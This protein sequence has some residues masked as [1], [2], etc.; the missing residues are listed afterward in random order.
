MKTCADACWASSSVRQQSPTS[1]ENVFQL[2]SNST[3][4]STASNQTTLNRSTDAVTDAISRFITDPFGGGE[5]SSASSSNPAA[6]V[7]KSFADVISHTISSIQGPTSSSSVVQMPSW[8]P[9]EAVNTATV[10]TSSDQT[11]TSNGNSTANANATSDENEEELDPALGLL[12]VLTHASTLF[13][14][15][16]H[17]DIRAAASVST[18]SNNE[19][20]VKSE[21]SASSMPSP[22]PAARTTESHRGRGDLSHVGQV[23]AQQSRVSPSSS[24]SSNNNSSRPSNLVDPVIIGSPDIGMDGRDR[25][26]A[27]GDEGGSNDDGRDRRDGPSPPGPGRGPDPAPGPGA[28][29]GAGPAGPGMN[30]EDRANLERLP[31]ACKG[32]QLFEGAK[33][34]GWT[35]MS[36]FQQPSLAKAASCLYDCAR[37]P[38]ISQNIQ[39]LNSEHAKEILD[40]NAKILEEAQKRRRKE[41]QESTPDGL[42][43]GVIGIQPIIGGG[44]SD[45]YD[46]QPYPSTATYEGAGP[47]PAAGPF[48]TPTAGPTSSR[49]PSRTPTPTPLPIRISGDGP[50]PPIPGARDNNRNE[51]EYEYESGYEPTYDDD[52]RRADGDRAGY[53]DEKYGDGN[54][55]R[56][57]DRRSGGYS[58]QSYRYDNERYGYENERGNDYMDNQSYRSRDQESKRKGPNTNVASERSDPSFWDDYFQ[59]QRAL[60]QVQGRQGR[61][62]G[63]FAAQSPRPD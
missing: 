13:G 46:D 56:Y 2:G 52:R 59:S 15:T 61:S 36:I 23:F 40:R 57:G 28:G 4:N 63:S 58:D 6:S 11:T 7:V 31:L 60:G 29:A 16:F 54:G 62:R 5:S 24:S 47:V 50:L 38:C 45:G 14:S 25:R 19:T 53:T 34:C 42:P 17:D 18:L 9:K 33:S 39:Q 51:Y 37:E 10:T 49:A 30:P 3:S 21:P 55:Y 48:S 35:C 22:S 12:G 20:A 27:Y 32:K 26:D 1:P 43:D 44:E 8:V 41:Q